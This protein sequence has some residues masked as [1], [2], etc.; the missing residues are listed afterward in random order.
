MT[1]AVTADPTLAS[2][3]PA[4][5]ERVLASAQ[6][7]SWPWAG[8][9]PS[10]RAEILDGIAEALEDNS[11]ELVALAAT[12]T[13]LSHDRLI[14]ELKRTA[15]QLRLFG[16]VLRDGGYLD[17][18]IDRPDPH[19]PSGAPRPD[20]RRSNRPIGPVLVFSASNFPFAFSVAGGD[21]ASALAAGNPVI[22]KAHSGHSRLS[23]RTA[24]VVLDACTR[25]GVPDGV[26]ALISGTEAGAEALKDHRIMAAGFTGSIA[27]GRALM[28]I[29]VSRPV[30]I[31]F[32]GELG[33]NNPV[34]VT[35]AAAEA[36]GAT[37]AEGYIAS[38][39]LG[40]GQYCV[41]PGTLF[42]PAGSGM[43]ERLRAAVL[44]DGAKLLNDR[45]QQ[46]YTASLRQ[47]S[48]HPH[49]Q[50]LTQGP[51]P[52]SGAPS[53]TL[54]LTTAEHVLSAPEE[55]EA[56]CFGPTSIVV[57]YD[58]ISELVP[59]AQTFEGQLTATIQ[60]E[61]DCPVADLVSVLA[62]KAGRLLWN[63]WPTGVAVT[64][65]QQHGG[66]YP[67]ST[68]VASTSVGTSAIE[69]FLRPV[70][71]QGFPE[72]LLPKELQESNPLEVPR[73]INGRR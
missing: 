23:H 10:R 12:E 66:P 6:A 27:G 58:D 45:I 22:V 20:L 69:R 34:F 36:R 25:L 18:R 46:G 33:S 57:E 52:F 44:P 15:F 72:H 3:S 67:A 2:T 50:V 54:L 63:E 37:I 29:A 35:P 8:F 38:F 60:S 53:P 1:T 56:E 55:L 14:G 17:A 68:A 40:A 30:P 73:M 24:Q 19:W 32:Y 4:E 28:D 16:E 70:A 13:N 21:T 59:L 31:P 71:Y 42:V 41:K 5:L 48:A 11:D 47:L 64:Y 65:A 26:F 49:V 39:T 7:A 9:S 62:E 61:D 43:V 51:N